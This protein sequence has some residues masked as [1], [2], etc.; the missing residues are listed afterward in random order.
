MKKIKSFTDLEAWKEAHKLVLMVYTFTKNFPSD[1]RFGLTNQSRRAAISITS[2]IAEGFGRKSAK[3][4]QH[5]YTMSATS[6]AELQNQFLTARD[7][8]Y[9]QKNDFKTFADQSVRVGMLISGLS[10]SAT[11]KI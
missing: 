6:L 7:L 4:K 2:N 9:L 1:E 11:D 5:F 3:D 8:G 10:K